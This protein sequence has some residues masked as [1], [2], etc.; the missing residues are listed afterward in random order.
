MCLSYNMLYYGRPI[1]TG[2]LRGSLG[3]DCTAPFA[4]AEARVHYGAACVPGVVVMATGEMCGA[5]SGNPKFYWEHSLGRRKSTMKSGT[6]GKQH[7]PGALAGQTAKWTLKALAGL[8]AASGAVA[9]DSESGSDS[10]AIEEI[11]VTATYRQT[12]LMDTPVS[13][14]AADA[15][16]IDQIGARDMSGLFRTLPGLNMVSG[17]TGTNR[18]VVRGISSQVGQHAALQTSSSVAVY[19]DDTPMTS[20]NGPIRQLGGTLFDIERV[21][22]LKGPQGTLFG[23][24]SQGGTVRY[25]Y[26]APDPTGVD[27]R[28]NASYAALGHSGDASYRFDGMINLPLADNFAVRLSAFTTEDGGFIDKT[29]STPVEEDVNSGE[30]TG[31]RLSA[32]WRPSEQFTVQAT[33]YWVDAEGK[34][35]PEAYAAY[36]EDRNVPIPGFPAESSDEF[37]L[38][39][40][41]LDWETD[42]ATLTSTT[43]YFERDVRSITHY[44]PNVAFFLDAVYGLLINLEPFFG[45]LPPPIPC[46]PGAQD[47]FLSNFL[48]CPYGDGLSL[49][50]WSIDSNSETDR[51]IQE[52]RA[53]SNNDGAFQ[54]TAGFFYK[55][56]DDFRADPQRP[57][58]WPGREA[59]VAIMSTLMMDPA[60]VH[61][62]TLKEVAGFAEA[63]YALSDLFEITAGARVSNLKQ[64]FQR[65]ETGT[66]DTVVSPKA[67]L[68]FRPADNQLYYFTYAS[69]FRPGS[70]NNSMEFNRRSFSQAGFPQSLVDKVAGLIHYQGD[71]IDSFELGAKIGFAD[72]RAQLIA[73]AYYQDWQDM[74]S[75]FLDPT[76]PGFVQQYHDNAGAAESRGIEVEF[77]WEVV[78]GLRL[79]FAADS[80]DSEAEE[81]PDLITFTEGN[82]LRYAPE[83]TIAASVD[84]TMEL[85]GALEGRV[86]V[87]HQR[88]GEQWQDIANTILIDEYNI[89]HARVTLSSRSDRRWSA[90]LFV[91]NL[92]DDEIIQDK[93]NYFIFGGSIADVYAPPRMVGVEFSWRAH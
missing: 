59:T 86:R 79:R 92:F 32:K 42:W 56:S 6:L 21:E 33:G 60:E 11:I 24:G 22:V 71:Q 48:A 84:Y 53:L 52:F 46:T 5:G 14:S 69:G 15:D 85:P 4:L 63:S 61:E 47:A 25:I 82:S 23:E 3:V 19:L 65:T 81:G 91:N 8:L 74:I 35:A 44:S 13:V 37:S 39:N 51:F 26:N 54:W 55:K 64:D 83:W 73:A 27:Y 93:F 20:A 41:R 57:F 77:N 1:S 9:Q 2:S 17:P 88:V 80:N 10:P 68:A 29:N 72:G 76:L 66:D 7:Q 90:S 38:Y 78:D 36:E 50:G 34:G 75:E 89:T 30:A 70:V 12:S 43:S 87:D 62:T 49:Q 40:L 45:G 18:M 58:A 28:I 16:M 67:T 31:G